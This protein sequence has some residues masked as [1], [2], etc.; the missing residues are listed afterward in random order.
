MNE[1]LQGNCIQWVCVYQCLTLNQKQRGREKLIVLNVPCPS[2]GDGCTLWFGFHDCCYRG[3][4]TE[5]SYLAIACR[6]FMPLVPCCH[7]YPSCKGGQ[8]K[9]YTCLALAITHSLSHPCPWEGIWNCPYHHCGH[10]R[11]EELLWAE[12]KDVE[13]DHSD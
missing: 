10:L 4:A 9:S 13:T 11:R 5:F 2:W 6:I 12:H 3:G 1:W 8:W 7:H